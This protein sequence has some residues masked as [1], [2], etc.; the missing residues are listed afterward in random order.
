MVAFGTNG[1]ELRPACG[2]WSVRS[3]LSCRAAACCPA[4]ANASSARGSSRAGETVGSVTPD[5][6]VD[7]L[8]G[9]HRATL[10]W[11]L[12]ERETVLTLELSRDGKAR[13]HIDDCPSGTS[14]SFGVPASLQLASE[15][16]LVAHQ[17]DFVIDLNVNGAM[18]EPAPFRPYLRYEE[19]FA[20][21]VTNPNTISGPSVSFEI[22]LD[23]STL[24]PKNTTI[25]V[26]RS[27]GGVE[28]IG[29][30]EFEN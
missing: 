9:T 30:V 11:V 12:A 23:S 3:R 6:T 27:A 19:L 29:V 20:A 8:L 21:G 10:T 13:E 22:L 14:R 24:A 18:A 5:A 16:G 28:T 1:R 4:L 2:C 15:D 17:Q 7:P 26:I 25:D